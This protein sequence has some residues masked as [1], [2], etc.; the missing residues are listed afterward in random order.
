MTEEECYLT[1]MTN[2]SGDQQKRRKTRA[3]LSGSSSSLEQ[4]SLNDYFQENYNTIN[5]EKQIYLSQ[6][7]GII[8]ANKNCY[9]DEI[10]Q[11][12]AK[13]MNIDDFDL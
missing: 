7:A 5:F 8:L 6:K 3:R 10:V 11:K 12:A 2:I 13:F 4:N 9:P 1:P